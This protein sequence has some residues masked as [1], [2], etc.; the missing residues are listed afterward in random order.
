MI[1]PIYDPASY[2]L[3]AEA[4]AAINARVKAKVREFYASGR[5]TAEDGLKI[6]EELLREDP[7]YRRVFYAVEAAREERARMLAE[8]EAPIV[9]DLRAAG[10]RVDSVWDVVNSSEPYFEALPVLMD[11]LERGGY[12]DR[13]MESL[14]RALAV[15]PSVVYWDRLKA[16]YLDPR[17]SGEEEGAAIALAAAATKRQ[18]PD[19]IGF[20]EDEQRGDVRIYFLRPIKRLGGEEGLQL[21]ERLRDDPVLGRE[22]TALLRKRRR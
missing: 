4:V 3:D 8:A 16:R 19:L 20:V 6:R 17:G 18:L 11:H 15:K 2:G 13:V 22:A 7:E 10:F 9:R 5:N 1:D 14:G 12:P 21:L